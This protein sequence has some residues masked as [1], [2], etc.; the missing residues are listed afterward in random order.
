MPFDTNVFINCPFDDA[1]LPLLRPILFAIVDLG[2]TPRIAL[3]SLDSGAPRLRKIIDLIDESKFSIHDISRLKAGKRG[4]YARLNMPF[5]LGLDIGRRLF[6]APPG[7][8][9][10][11]LILEAEPYRYQAALSDLSNCD[12]A[13]HDGE[14]VRAMTAVRDWLNTQAKLRAPGPAKVWSRFGEFT[15]FNYDRLIARGYSPDDIKRLP[16]AELIDDIG[17]WIQHNSG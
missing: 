2:F 5:E 4:E 16:V 7:N 17:L 12:I 15:G 3:E 6:G 9:K 10:R 13:S 8:D 1:Y 14:P 11:C